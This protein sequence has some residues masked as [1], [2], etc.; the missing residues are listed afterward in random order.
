MKN[1]AH[2]AW[3]TVGLADVALGYFVI[4]QWAKSPELGLVLML[5]GTALA[6]V[7]ALEMRRPKAVRL[8][9]A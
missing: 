2:L 8:G 7:M 9:S 6:G 4:W 5:L 1:A 3:L